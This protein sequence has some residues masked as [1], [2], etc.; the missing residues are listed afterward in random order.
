MPKPKSKLSMAQWKERARDVLKGW[1]NSALNQGLSISNKDKVLSRPRIAGKEVVFVFDPIKITFDDG[2]GGTFTCTYDIRGTLASLG[3]RFQE[4]E[5][6]TEAEITA[7][8]GSENISLEEAMARLSF[9]YVEAEIFSKLNAGRFLHDQLGPTLKEVIGEL[10]D[11]AFMYGIKEYGMVLL[12]PTKIFEKLG[13]KHIK[14]L[15]QRSGLVPKPGRPPTQTREEV[16]KRVTTAMSK[17]KTLPT[18]RSTAEVMNLGGLS[19]GADALRKLLKKHKINWLQLKENWK[20]KK[21]S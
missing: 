17:Q 6:A 5:V 2:N 9:R 16:I 20:V 13:R 21:R 3:K 4:L 15:K 14:G 10:I 1:A 7:Y 19:G 11:A 12:E 8:A 18:Y